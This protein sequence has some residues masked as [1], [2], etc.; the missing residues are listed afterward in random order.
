M[1]KMTMPMGTLTNMTQRHDTNSVSKP[2]NTRPSAPPA[3]DT[4]V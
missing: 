3:A 4:D 2:P 1:T